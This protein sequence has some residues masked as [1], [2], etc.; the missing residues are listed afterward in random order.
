V[1]RIA[2][3]ALLIAAVLIPAFQTIV[4]APAHADV[5]AVTL[6]TDAAISATALR[7]AGT[8][9]VDSAGNGLK[10]AS[11][12]FRYPDT[13]VLSRV[14]RATSRRPGFLAI[15]ATID[16]TRIVAGANQLTVVDDTDGDSRTINL[17]LRRVSRVSITHAEFRAHGRIALAV[18]ATH[19][20]PRSNHFVGS[21]L[22]PVRL[23]EKLSGT[24][25]TI[26]SATTDSSGLAGALVPAASGV[27]YYR[28]VRP[29]GA[30]VLGATS[31]TIRATRGSAATSLPASNL[32]VK[33]PI[34]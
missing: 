31:L 29:D 34:R 11:L 33:R 6:P 23:Q 26:A 1:K 25:T 24:W 10:S 4:A 13:G 14:G 3:A 2:I 8:V 15:T 28:V 20:D 27:H 22:S 5:V 16:T 9:R 12:W 32:R 19:Y 17:D 30:T 21:K 18:R 7:L